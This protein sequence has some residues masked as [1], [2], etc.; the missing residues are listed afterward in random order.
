MEES[1]PSHELLEDADWF[2]VLVVINQ[3][4]LG[5][6]ARANPSF[7]VCPSLLERNSLWMNAH[8]QKQRIITSPLSKQAKS[9]LAQHQQTVLS[10]LRLGGAPSPTKPEYLTAV[11]EPKAALMFA[12]TA[13]RCPEYHIESMLSE[14]DE[15]LQSRAIR[16]QALRSGFAG[17]VFRF[18]T[19]YSEPSKRILSLRIL[20]RL[21]N[22][23]SAAVVHACKVAAQGQLWQPNMFIYTLQKRHRDN[24]EICALVAELL[25]H[26]AGEMP[27]ASPIKLDSARVENA[28]VDMHILSLATPTKTGHTRESRTTSLPLLS[29]TSPSKKTEAFTHRPT[30][31]ISSLYVDAT[32]PYSSQ[33]VLPIARPPPSASEQARRSVIFSTPKER[34]LPGD[35]KRRCL[36]PNIPEP[37]RDACS[38]SG[39]DLIWLGSS[40]S[41]PKSPTTTE[42]KPVVVSEK[43]SWNPDCINSVSGFEWWWRSLPQHHAN[44]EPTQKLKMVTKAAV[45]LH[46][47]GEW[48]RAVELYLLALSM[49]I[50]DEVQFRLRINLGCAY[51]VGQEYEASETE[52]RAALRINAEDPYAQFKLGTSLKELGRLEEAKTVFESVLNVYPQAEESLKRIEQLQQEK[53]KREEAERAFVA[54]A[55]TA[56]SPSKPGRKLHARSHTANEISLPQLHRPQSPVVEPSAPPHEQQE[57]K[58]SDTID[59]SVVSTATAGVEEPPPPQAPPK[60]DMLSAITG[61]L[62]GRNIDLRMSFRLLDPAR[63]GLLRVDS[64]A[65]LVGGL[66][67]VEASEF[68]SWLPHPAVPV[69]RGMVEYTQ[70][71]DAIDSHDRTSNEDQ[72]TGSERWL[73]LLETINKEDDLHGEAQSRDQSSVTIEKPADGPVEDDLEPT[74]VSSN[75]GCAQ[76]VNEEVGVALDTQRVPSTQR[77]HQAGELSGYDSLSARLDEK[78]EKAR[79]DTIL[80]TE[81]SR[82]VARK[83]LHCHTAL[84][85]IGARARQQL[86]NQHEARSFLRSVGDQAITKCRSQAE[87]IVNES[88]VENSAPA[89]SPTISVETSAHDV[90]SEASLPPI[91]QRFV[92]DAVN[93]A[94]RKVIVARGVDEL[95]SLAVQF[96]QACCVPEN[97]RSTQG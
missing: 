86:L 92:D 61:S 16:V 56:R 72:V 97:L 79:Q 8:F 73:Q 27:I 28:D 75:E 41:P 57:T 60:Q 55:R 34:A 63:T 12:A 2:N 25:A 24:I 20:V 37:V 26:F 29:T 74:T 42:K 33:L 49:D 89:P 58:G 38:S 19:T 88:L 69:D 81:R 10:R 84:Q 48:E 77:A 54:S 53:L 23:D 68:V 30:T 95:R 21:A 22:E 96:S 80:R 62:R 3:R 4:W 91:G 94:I 82:V 71:L 44:L 78:R 35:R 76:S 14:A 45:R 70:L 31:T 15:F 5:A 47:K 51:E 52:F 43:Y 18:L 39:D 66:I 32:S 7:C 67:G 85:E 6:Y 93:A 65:R 17:C 11:V 59:V 50:S 36:T 46:T 13:D 40:D 83:H 64:V 87:S 1:D 90:V 9:L